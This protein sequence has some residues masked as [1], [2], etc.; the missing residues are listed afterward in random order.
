MREILAKALCELVRVCVPHCVVL[1]DEEVVRDASKTRIHVSKIV[2][3]DLIQNG[4]FTLTRMPAHIKQSAC[5]IRDIL[6]NEVLDGPLF[7]VSTNDHMVSRT[8]KHMEKR[9]K[10][11]DS[12]L[13]FHLGIL[14]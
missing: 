11:L 6:F 7:V 5:I 4:C 3:K 13:F 8:A 12:L 9:L 10:C 2:E 14:V 1:E